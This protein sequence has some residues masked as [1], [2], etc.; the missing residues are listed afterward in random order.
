MKR[1]GFTLIELLIV[2]AIIGILA[3]IA[4]PN[5]MNA[6]I[7]AKIARSQADLRSTVTAIEQL[8]LDRNLMLVDFWDDDT[9]WG[10]DRIVKKF[11]GVGHNGGEGNRNQLAVLSPLTSPVSYIASVPQDPFA[12][13]QNTLTSGHKELYG[14]VGNDVYLYTDNDPEGSGYDYGG[15]Q[16]DPPLKEG[17]YTLYAFGPAAPQIYGNG[18]GV[19]LGIPYDPS[20]GMISVGDIIY[21]SQG[22][23]FN[24]VNKK[25]GR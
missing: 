23:G 19:R 21:R 5:F 4:V 11:N 22:G 13:K 25:G 12:A 2:V 18:N 10:Q 14:R 15:T 1:K 24:A 7:R 6:Q 9:T 8:I 16:W 17:E 3:A 20:N